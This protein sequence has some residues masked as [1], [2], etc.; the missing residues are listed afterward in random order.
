MEANSE[1][2]L[3]PQ[4]LVEVKTRRALPFSFAKRHGVLIREIGDEG[5]EAVYRSGATALSLA[6]VRR[7]AGVPMA[8]SR[9]S[10][11]VFDTLLQESYEQD[12]KNAAQMMDGLDEEF[13]LTQFAQDLEPSDLLES[14]DDAP[15][16]R[17][18]NA[19]LTEAIKENASDVHIETYENRLE[20]AISELTASCATYCKLAVRSRRWSS[21]ESRS[22]RASISLRS[23][24]RRMVEFHSKSADVQ[25]MFVFQR[26]RPGMANASYCDCSTNRRAVSTSSRWAWIRNFRDEHDG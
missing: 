17:F 18:I 25:S 6:E 24:C 8:L 23:A 21:P 9:V 13:D 12:S 11:E 16:I 26:C 1:I 19:V 2:V 7:F 22:C 5:G 14:D 15:I 4:E 10:A 3:D 20:R